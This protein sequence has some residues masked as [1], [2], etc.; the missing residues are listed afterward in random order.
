MDR[1]SAQISKTSQIRESLVLRKLSVIQDIL[2]GIHSIVLAT[3][4]KD[5]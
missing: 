2:F 3:L 4:K 5:N 1:L